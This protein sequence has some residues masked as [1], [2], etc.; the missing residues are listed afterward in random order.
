M[1]P[2]SIQTR[3]ETRRRAYRKWLVRALALVAVVLLVLSSVFS[4]E[5]HSMRSSR[6]SALSRQVALQAQML[7][8]SDPK[9]ALLLAMVGYH[10]SQTE[11]A[12]STLLDMVA[13]TVPDSTVPALLARVPANTAT[14]TA[15]TPTTTIVE[16]DDTR[17]AVRKLTRGATAWIISGNYQVLYVGEADGTIHLWNLNDP[18]AP[19]EYTHSPL[20]GP[21]N[22]I[23]RLVLSPDGATLAA[24]TSTGTVWL[25]EVANPNRTSRKATLT[26]ADT[27]TT[28][29]TIT[30]LQF[31]EDDNTL[32]AGLG[33]GHTVVWHYRPYQVI[34]HICATHPATIPEGLWQHYLPGVS[35]VQ[36]CEHWTPP[37]VPI[38]AW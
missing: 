25:W 30:S 38:A 28:H 17:S 13:E 33:D 8:P 4:R 7:L 26:A 29:T 11:N 5:F 16:T 2:T 34:D 32:L 24:S 23:Q 10:T 37:T 22:P 36:P 6:D 27:S 3:M 35:N 18:T 15:T 1:L 19:T 21:A 31:T 9:L 20:V 12:R 14:I